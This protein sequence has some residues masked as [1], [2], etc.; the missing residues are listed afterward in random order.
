MVNGKPNMLWLRDCS[1]FTIYRSLFF[2]ML[3]ALL[4]LS[5]PKDALC[6]LDWL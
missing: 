3:H 2:A 4:V 6:D 1:P 5:L